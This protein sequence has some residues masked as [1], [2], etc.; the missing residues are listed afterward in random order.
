M[1]EEKVKFW[2]MV[3]SEQ[4]R[5]SS[6]RV[7][8]AFM[9]MVCLGILIGFAATEGCTDNVKSLMDLVLVLS[10][11]LLGISSITGIWKNKDN[12]KKEVEED[13]TKNEP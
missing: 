13:E 3:F 9:I 1:K 11:S 4:G 10:S 2:K 12:K 8:G 5:P 7:L 6:K